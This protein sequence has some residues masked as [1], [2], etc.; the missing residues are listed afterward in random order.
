MSKVIAIVCQKGGVG[1]TTT[2]VH[3]G[4]GLAR[5]G[6]KVLLIDADSQ[7]SMTISLGH[8]DSRNY[9]N[10]LDSLMN[11]VIKKVTIDESEGIIACKENVD[12][13]AANRNLA[14]IEILI[15]T[16]ISREYILKKYL[17]QVK[18][19]YDYVIIDTPPS[20]GLLTIN[21]MAAA[22][23][24]IIPVQTEY[25]AAKGLEELLRTVS[26]IQEEINETL[27]IDGML[28][29]MVDNRTNES[30]DVAETITKTYGNHIRILGSIPRLVKVSESSRIGSSL[31]EISAKNKA[32][33]AYESFVEEVI[34]N[35]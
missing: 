33:I 21:A 25:L 5:E 8:R 6:K 1:K 17:K 14:A 26:D 23:S 22:D 18:N 35:G 16:E 4:I 27:E 31:F 7:G 11:K 9:V 29:T 19:N 13:I 30:K 24:V 34:Q 3:L 32:T 20:L 10:T 28:F 15:T 12:L 2:A